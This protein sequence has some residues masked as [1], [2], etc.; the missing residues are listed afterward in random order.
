MRVVVD[1][2]RCQGYANCV[3]V[4]P[5]I[6]DL[7]EATGQALV[8]QPEPGEELHDAARAA[9]AGCPVQAISVEEEE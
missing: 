1:L 5:E 7:D 4:A 3:G 2:S 9:V 6:F 8:I